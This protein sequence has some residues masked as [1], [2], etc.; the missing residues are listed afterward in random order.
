MEHISKVSVYILTSVSITI[1]PGSHIGTNKLLLA[2]IVK[3]VLYVLLFSLTPIVLI[4]SVISYIV[5]VFN[6]K[7]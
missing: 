7:E 2:F 3:A 4:K 1:L 5:N 6:N